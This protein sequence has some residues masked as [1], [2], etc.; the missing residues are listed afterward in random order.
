[1]VQRHFRAQT[2]TRRKVDFG[3]ETKEVEK[4]VEGH[5][6]PASRNGR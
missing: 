1:M 3:Q 5:K 2:K 4:D 6:P